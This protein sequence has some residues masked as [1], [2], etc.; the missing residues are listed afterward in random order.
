MFYFSPALRPSYIALREIL[1][2]GFTQRT[3]DKKHAKA[4]SYN[5]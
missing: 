5:N 3:E 2:K 1:L 4:Q